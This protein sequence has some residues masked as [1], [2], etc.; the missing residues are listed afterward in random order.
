MLNRNDPLIGAVQEVMRKNQAERDA[1]RAVNEKFGVTDRRAL[2]HEQQ[3]NW[4]AA[5]NKV[6]SEGVEVLNEAKEPW[7]KEGSWSKQMKKQEKYAMKMLTPKAKEARDKAAEK[8][9]DEE[10]SPKQQKLAAIAGDKKKIDA[11]DLA[12]ARAGKASHIEEE[13]ATAASKKAEKGTKWKVK[14][15]NWDR[16]GSEVEL[17]QGK[18]VKMK[19]TYDRNASMFTMSNTK[20]GK[21]DPKSKAKDYDDAKDVLKTVKESE[22]ID[23][24]LDTP[25]KRLKY[26]AKAA[27]SGIKANMKGDNKTLAKRTKGAEMAGRKTRAHIEKSSMDDYHNKVAGDILNNMH[28]KANG[29]KEEQIDESAPPGREDQVKALKD[30]VGKKSAFAIAWASYNKKKGK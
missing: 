15:R 17:R 3:A 2:P 5:Y 23:E 27:V 22:Q 4:D 11:P 16:D 6:I 25:G 20:K 24:V 30:K 8:P 21:F 19:G 12:A 7:K 26:Y 14:S 13:S 18:R 28:K 1:V 9:M 10:L 29:L